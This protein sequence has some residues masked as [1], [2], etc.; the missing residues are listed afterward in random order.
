MHAVLTT[1]PHHHDPALPR[2]VERRWSARTAA[3]ASVDG[4]YGRAW[5]DRHAQRAAA[6]RSSA[7]AALLSV[8]DADRLASRAG[9]TSRVGSTCTCSRIWCARR[10]DDHSVTHAAD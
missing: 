6:L 8:A 3:D 10:I 5:L 2:R 1:M 9:G 7:C 4:S